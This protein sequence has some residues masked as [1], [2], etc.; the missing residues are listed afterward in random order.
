MRMKRVFCF[1]L[2]VCLC[3]PAF[4]A[5][6]GTPALTF[7]LAGFDNSQYREWAE[8][9]FFARMEEKTGVHFDVT[10]YKDE[11]SWTQAKA[12]MKAGAED[13]P[14][15]LFKARLTGDECIRLRESGVL[16]D[17]KPY[18]EACCPNLWAIMQE[19]PE[20]LSAVTLPDGS[21]AA[22]P[23]ISDPSMQ[24][25]IWVNQEW[26][27]NLRLDMPANAQEFADMLTA[28]K[29]RDPNRNGRADEIPLGFLGP[30]DLKFLAHAFGL[31]A[32]DYNVFV[33]DG[34][35]RFMPLE[36]NFRPFIAWCRDLR[37]AGLLDKNGFSITDDMRTVTDSNAKATYGAI[38][39]PM[40]ADVFKVSWAENYAIMPPLSYNGQQV[41]RDFSGSA[42]RGTFAVTSHCSDPETVLRW[43][44][45]L[46]ALDGAILAGIGMRDVDYLVDGDG[47][48]RYLDAVQ[49]NFDTFRG[50]TLIEGGSA[51][52]PGI[53]TGEFERLMSGNA[54]VTNILNQQ[55]DFHQ[56]VRMP[57]PYY[58]LTKEQSDT[59]APL[60]KEL[61]YYVDM[62]IARWVLGEEEI[63]DE[64]FAAFEEK[65]N[66]LGLNEFLSFWQDVLN[67]M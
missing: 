61:G 26:L 36:E 18:L 30:F 19:K 5:A 65:L 25:Y 10:Q 64:S 12:A 48:W 34:Q 54:M 50:T 1:L 24:N 31:I 45:E 32:N 22:L 39:T 11:A 57:F 51:E 7:T 27:T 53:S 38:I 14:D 52:Q 55:R 2:I 67:R 23:F 49:S 44:D 29:T 6:E 46:Y 16:I 8:N 62:Q 28:F 9:K 66:E 21:V 40:A 43:V 4:A 58:T 59:V 60:Q 13:L 47:T 42:L 56:Y 33:Q 20:V 3:L 17:L 63:S 41:Y 37:D 15:V 35:V